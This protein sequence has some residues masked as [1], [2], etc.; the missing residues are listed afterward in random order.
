MKLA[1]ASPGAHDRE[2]AAAP[3]DAYGAPGG[4]VGDRTRSDQEFQ[5]W[6]SESWPAC[7]PVLAVTFTRK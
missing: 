3:P 4:A 7:Q 1:L 2:D 5:T 6:N